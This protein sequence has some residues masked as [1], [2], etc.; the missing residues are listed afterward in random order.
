M[1]KRKRMIVVFVLTVALIITCV[2][3]LVPV[4][5]KT[6]TCSVPSLYDHPRFSI[7]FGQS[8]EFEAAKSG[9]GPSSPA[10]GMCT[11]PLKVNLY[12]L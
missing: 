6:L 5:S 1:K 9:P 10:E 8:A 12:L 3:C 11:A 7:L 4:S 2:L